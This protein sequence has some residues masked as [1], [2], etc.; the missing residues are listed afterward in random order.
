MGT[1]DAEIEEE[2]FGLGTQ[3]FI[4]VACTFSNEQ[5]VLR[6]QSGLIIGCIS[7]SIALF[8]MVYIDY[9]KQIQKTNFVEWDVK[10]ITAGD[11]AIEFDVTE[12]FYRDFKEKK[13]GDK[14]AEM[15][16]ARYFAV[17][18]QKEVEDK[19]SQIP[20]LGYMNKPIQKINVAFVNLAYDNSQ[21]IN[22]LKERGTFIKTEK[23][24]KM[25]EVEKKIDHIRKTEMHKLQRPCSV[26]MCFANE[27]GLARALKFHEIT[28]NSDMLTLRNLSSF[29]GEPGSKCEFRI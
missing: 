9:I 3:A 7:I 26:F 23:W 10:T 18:L 17:W 15:P 6:Q 11:Y 4:Q 12:K 5:V 21:V 25:R 2:C 24:D 22:L 14:P 20:D 28:E 27:E 19:L 29:L 8:M 16:W 13:A 1:P